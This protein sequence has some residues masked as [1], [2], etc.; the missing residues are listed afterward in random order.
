MHTGHQVPVYDGSLI[1]WSL[2]PEL[3]ME[4]K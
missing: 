3:P 1:E 4:P 2:H